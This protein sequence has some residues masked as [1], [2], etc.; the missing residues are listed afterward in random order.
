VCHPGGTECNSLKALTSC[1]LLLGEICCGLGS[2]PLWL[3]R[4]YLVIGLA[5]ELV[6]AIEQGFADVFD[7]PADR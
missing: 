1:V 6:F 5:Q 7:A 4:G 2:L 3:R